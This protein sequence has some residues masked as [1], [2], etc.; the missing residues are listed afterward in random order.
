MELLNLIDFKMV[1]AQMVCFLLVLFLLRKFLWK[2]VFDVLE[3]R[4]TKVHA[5][6]QVVEAI[7]A[8]IQKI[9]ADYGAS[10]ARIDETSRERLKEIE[11]LGEERARDM[12][13]KAH[14]DADQII[15]EARQE[16]QFEILKARSAL[17]A[18]MVGMVIQATEKMI[19]EK[20]TFEEDKKLIDDFL[21]DM[22]QVD[23]R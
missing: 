17:R 8:D 3:A 19:Q 14:H 2:P 18:E 15:N 11:Q 20:L 1:L 12:K 4:R 23:A 10:M 16:V 7:K 5:D 9:K 21:N 6:L 13:V 22:D